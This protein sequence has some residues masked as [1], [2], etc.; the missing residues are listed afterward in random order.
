MKLT[1]KLSKC[2]DSMTVNMFDNGFMVEISG[3]DK[4]DDYK[5]AKIMCQTLAEVFAVIEAASTMPRD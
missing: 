3:R 2:S 4:E 1:D 5:S